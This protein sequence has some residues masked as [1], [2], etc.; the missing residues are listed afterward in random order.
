MLDDLSADITAAP[1]AEHPNAKFT[2]LLV[3]DEPSVL[4][5]LRRLFRPEG[6][7]T[8]QATSGAEAIVLLG[9]EKIDLIISDMRMPEM[10]GAELLE[11]VRKRWPHITRILLTGYA[12]INST[13][14]AINNGE[15][16]R[17]IAKPWDDQALILLVREALSRRELEDQN[18]QLLL[19]TQAQNEELEELNRTLEARVAARVAEINQVADMLDA[20]YDDLSQTFNV[21]CTVFAGMLE[22]RQTG[23]AGHSRRVAEL[24]RQVAQELKV[25]ANTENEI[26]LAGLLHDIGKLGFPDSMLG[27]PVSQF[28]HDEMTRYREHPEQ[29]ETALMPLSRLQGVAHIVRQHHERVDGNGFPDGLVGH[30]IH[31]GAKI[32]AAVSDYD[33]LVHGGAAQLLH[34][35]EHALSIIKPLADKHYDKQVVAA[36]VKVVMTSLPPP[37]TEYPVAP[38]DLKP[39]M[40][41]ARDLLSPKGTLL[42]P[43]GLVFNPKVILQIQRFASTAPIELVLPIQKDR[44]APP[45]QPPA[46][47]P[48]TS[49][50]TTATS[51]RS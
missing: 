36:L 22:M 40:R 10:D 45:K 4:S 24:S 47:P 3:D 41:L 16:H 19:K 8:I 37:V 43:K 46:P 5:A 49:P 27:K 15:I 42:L 48:E 21:A 33:G 17:Y 39:G 26:Y 23:M 31:I 44:L 25:D 30:Q 20:A 7:R 9:A 14:A 35:P 50:A 32:I 51:A 1:P 13:I 6:Y 34:D 12:D 18:R 2:L 38:A 28:T 29:G 11:K